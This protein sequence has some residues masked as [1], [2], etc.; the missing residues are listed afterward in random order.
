MNIDLLK[1]ICETPGVPGYEQAVRSLV[2]KEVSHLVDHVWVD[3]I[4]NVFALKKGTRNPENKKVMVAA[5]MDEIGFIISHI[6]EQ[7][8]LRFQT[9]GGFDPKTLT[10][11]RVIVHGKKDLVGVMGAKPIHVMSPEEKNKPAKIEDF[12][13]DLGMKKEEV[14]QYISIGDTVTRERSLIEMGDCINCKSLDNRISVFILIETLRLLQYSSVPYDFYAV[15]TVQE[16][17]GLRG[18][19]VA[20]HSLN[21]DFA[22]ALDTTIAYDVPGARPHEKCT[23]LGKGTAI[24]ILDSSTICDYRMVAYLKKQAQDRNI[25]WQPEILVAGG[26][27]TA[28]LQRNGKNGSIA[29]AISIPT[30]HIH[31]VIEMVNK[32]DVER[33]IQLL[34]AA[35]ENLDQYSWNH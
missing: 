30:R 9:L 31:Q 35:V 20:A 26:T 6:D 28:P 3:N 4:G 33:S 18:A 19:G 14:D 29:G 13:I 17:V 2:L 34:Q 25:M 8:F 32:E 15:F 24:K 7:G 16:E 10:A 11:Q 22:I 5:H 1:N 21:P 27:D 23:E 12:F